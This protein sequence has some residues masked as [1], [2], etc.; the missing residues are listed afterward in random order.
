MN[1]SNSNI[2]SNRPSPEMDRTT[3]H[4]VVVTSKN[5]MDTG[6]QVLERIREVVDA[7][8]GWVKVETVRKAKDMC[9]CVFFSVLN[10]VLK[11][12]SDEKVKRVLKNQNREVF[13]DPNDELNRMEVKCR[14][15]TRNPHAQKLH[16][17]VHVTQ[18][19]LT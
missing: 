19:T 5:D 12:H 3:L 11:F 14:K 16:T 15:R 2:K 7:K 6:E 10:G 9:I 17:N 18:Y 13:G 4:S 1:M 8:E